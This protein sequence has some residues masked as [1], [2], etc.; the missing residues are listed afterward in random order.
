MSRLAASSGKAS[1]FQASSG[2]ASSLPEEATYSLTSYTLTNLPTYCK[3]VIT[4]GAR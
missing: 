4:A 3:N 2:K 1:S